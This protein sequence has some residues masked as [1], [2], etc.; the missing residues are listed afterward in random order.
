MVGD[1]LLFSTYVMSIGFGIFSMF[2]LSF[3]SKDVHKFTVILIL[4]TTL[5]IVFRMWVSSVE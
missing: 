1:I 2:N 4:L 3:S 5:N